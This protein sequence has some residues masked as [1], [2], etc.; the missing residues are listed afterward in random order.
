MTYDEVRFEAIKEKLSK[1]ED[2]VSRLDDLNGKKKQIKRNLAVLEAEAHNEQVDVI[3]L[4]EKTF[5]SVV[6]DILGKKEQKLEKERAEAREAAAK[7]DAARLELEN[8]SAEVCACEVQIEGCEKEYISILS[9]RLLQI[10]KSSASAT[11]YAIVL[12]DI[13]ARRREDTEKL[14]AIAEVSQDAV[15]VAE[16]VI[17]EL[18]VVDDL[19]ARDIVGGGVLLKMR[20]HEHISEVE[21]LYRVLEKKLSAL[22]EKTVDIVIGAGEKIVLGGLGGVD[23]FFWDNFFTNWDM[24]DRVEEAQRSINKT[25]AQISELQARLSI[26]KKYNEAEKELLVALLDNSNAI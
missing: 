6:F 14:N 21:R 13:L 3:N 9:E 15:S 10:K 25:V 16:Q 22:N 18:S 5:T 26:I 8:I 7:R 11:E 24:V 1:R 23:D 17:E 19:V 4:E 12:S 20:K 2:L